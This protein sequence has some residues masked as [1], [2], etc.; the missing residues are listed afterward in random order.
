MKNTNFRYNDGIWAG[1]ELIKKGA[2][3]GSTNLDIKSEFNEVINSGKYD[4]YFIE[5]IKLVYY[6]FRMITKG[7]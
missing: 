6:N 7:E 1:L 4:K 3:N 2:L 5:G